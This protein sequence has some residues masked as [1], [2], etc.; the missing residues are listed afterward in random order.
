MLFDFDG[1]LTTRDT[2][3][4]FIKF[5]SGTIG[6]IIGFILL[7]PMLV[8]YKLKIVPNWRAKEY[9]LSYFFKGEH[10]DEFNTKGKAFAE[11]ILPA[12]IRKKTVDKFNRYIEQ[13]DMVIIVSASAVNWVKPWADKHG[14]ELIATNLEIKNDRLT[15]RILGR[16]CYGPEKVSRIKGQINLSDYSE[17]HVYGDSRGDRE[18]LDL[19]THAFYKK[20]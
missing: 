10:I 19:A 16:N 1:T 11:R 17:I 9:V 5:Y 7:S 6:F 18:M 14:V 13:G 15:G 2:F 8:L 3:I 4:E 12:M 20:F